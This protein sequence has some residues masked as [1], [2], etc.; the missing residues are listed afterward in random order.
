MAIPQNF[1]ALTRLLAS[2]PESN[3][4]P[5]IILAGDGQVQYANPAVERLLMALGF[6][7][8]NPAQLL[9]VDAAERLP[10][11]GQEGQAHWEYPVKSNQFAC[12][13]VAD[14]GSNFFRL[15]LSDITERKHDQERL[16][17]LAYY[18]PLTGLP[19]RAK[20]LSELHRE[21]RVADQ[22]AQAFALLVV[23]LDTFKLV[24]YTLGHRHGD[25]LLQQVAHRISSLVDGGCM[26][27]RFGEDEFA[28]VMRNI[29]RKGA[30]R[31]SANLVDELTPVYTLA[32]L[33]VD[34]P[35]SIGVVLYPEHGDSA[36][37]LI[38]HANIAIHSAREA[39]SRIA[40]YDPDHDNY[41]TRRL[42]LLTD[43]R[44]AINH[45]DLFMHY[46]PKI[47]LS[48][49]RV[50]G[51]EALIRWQH[52]DLGSIPADEFIPVAEGTYLI[53]PLTL[54]VLNDVLRTWRNRS[55]AL[56]G[57]RV[58][59]NLSA[60]NL[61]NSELPDILAGL[62]N[63]WK[64]DPATLVLEITES[65]LMVDPDSAMDVLNRFHQLGVGLSID[66]F[67]TGYSSLAYLSRLP[68]DE[69]KI[70]RSF[71]TRVDSNQGNAAIV[72][73]T[74]QLAHN[75]GMRVVAEGVETQAELSILG[76]CG[77]DTVQGYLFSKPLAVD[78]F[79]DWLEA[80]D[81]A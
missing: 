50:C 49:N 17:R 3:P 54:W 13:V 79:V 63:H 20:L 9:P 43:L 11:I 80:Q 5:V 23:D 10:A 39:N 24:S 81:M 45:G 66:D 42:T 46:Q 2:L 59:I 34:A 32:G 16:N 73:S 69:L 1:E 67:G 36:S 41:T 78:Q 53:E 30:L 62:L 56:D 70:D 31:L 52:A 21:I 77:C 28:V 37:S 4:T 72:R 19:N 47:D 27:A 26:I 71:V 33:L 38:Q 57:I 58:S 8:D 35:A 12:E 15:F 60:R 68:V 65:A 29:D 74:V 6:E 64:V 75:L 51:V 55:S 44:Q 48:G 14:T 18:D 25:L 61:N 76:D 7:S 40:I 22:T